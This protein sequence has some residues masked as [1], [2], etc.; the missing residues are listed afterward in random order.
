MIITLGAHWSYMTPDYVVEEMT[1]NEVGSALEYIYRYF[2]PMPASKSGN[3]Y[4][5]ISAF[6]ERGR[7][8]FRNDVK[9]M[10]STIK[11]GGRS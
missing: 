7:D 5:S 6:I 3:K 9:K 2:E 11:R 10:A 4:K 8:T 1:W